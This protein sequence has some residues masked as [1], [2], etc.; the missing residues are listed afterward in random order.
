LLDKLRENDIEEFKV[1]LV[2]KKGSD[3]AIRDMLEADKVASREEALIEIYK[4]MRPGEPATVETAKTF[5]EN[6]FFN[7][8]RYDL[9]RVGRLKVN[10]R[11][12]LN[13]PL[14]LTTLT[15]DD[16]IETIKVLNN[17]RLGE[18][19]VDDIDHLGHRRIKAVGE[20]LQNHIRIGMVRMEK[21]VKERMSIQDIKDLS[22]QDFL[23]AKP[24]SSSIKEFFGQL[25]AVSVYGSNKPFK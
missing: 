11:L 15:S 21:T 24:L 10:K 20:Q 16:I 5:F 6:L 3:S 13:K 22:P 4:K 25:P 8:K 7:D 12:K 17:I 18:D 1:L 2:D 14:D 9:S 19:T 23:N